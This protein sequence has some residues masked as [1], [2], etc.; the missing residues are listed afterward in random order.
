MGVTL[1]PIALPAFSASVDYFHIHLEGEIGTV[2]EAVTLNQCLA[3]GDPAWC[4]QIV[5][6]RAG[7]LSGTTVAGGGYIAGQDV[8]TGAALVSGTDLQM[9][10][11]QPLPAHWGML[12]VTLNGSY[13]Q[14]DSSTPYRSAPS[15]DCAG[16]CVE[17]ATV[18]A[19]AFH[20]THQLRQ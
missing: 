1:T 7:A 10:Y 19:V 16:L 11:R 12:N 8:N 4:S 17:A 18:G 9:D 2:P 14:H 3:T 13:L 20:R 6:T 15:Y 5:R